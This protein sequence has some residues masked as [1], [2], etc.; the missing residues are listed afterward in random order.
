MS[1]KMKIVGLILGALLSTSIAFAEGSAGTGKC[2]G[3]MKKE[4]KGSCGTGKCGGDMKQETKSDMKQEKA[5]GS[6]GAGKCG[7]SK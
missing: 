3:D 1:K 6:C 7:S 5:A 2:G 4:T